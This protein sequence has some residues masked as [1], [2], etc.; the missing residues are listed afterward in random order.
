MLPHY[1]YTPKL[2]LHHVMCKYAH[3]Y[4]HYSLYFY[5]CTYHLLLL[6]NQFLVSSL[7]S[8]LSAATHTHTPDFIFLLPIIKYILYLICNVCIIN[9]MYLLLHCSQT[10]RVPHRDNQYTEPHTDHHSQSQKRKKKQVTYKSSFGSRLLLQVR[11]TSRQD[12][13]S[14]HKITKWDGWGGRQHNDRTPKT[15]P[16]TT[17]PA[18]HASSCCLSICTH[19]PP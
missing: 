3:R 18:H 12:A 4:P 17:T 16:I 5:C 10:M 2:P 11:W 19:A 1:T 13:F 7:P 14:P 15:P 6:H 9:K 8:Y